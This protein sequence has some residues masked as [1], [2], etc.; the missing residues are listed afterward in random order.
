[1]QNIDFEENTKFYTKLYTSLKIREDMGYFMWYLLVGIL[2]CLLSTQTL[3]SINC[4]QS[5][6]SLEE[7]YNEEMNETIKKSSSESTSYNH[8][9][10]VQS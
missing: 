8:G 2:C 6:D 1:M 10:Y 7:E 5:L 4:S 3:L 9:P